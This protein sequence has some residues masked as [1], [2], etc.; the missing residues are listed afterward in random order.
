M[1]AEESSEVVLGG[2]VAYTSQKPWIMSRTVKENITFTLPYDE[3]KFRDAVK[4]ASLDK[5]LETLPHHE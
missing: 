2:S 1:Y 5:D 4:Y 3:K